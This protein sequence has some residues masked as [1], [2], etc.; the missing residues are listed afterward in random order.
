[1]VVF[2]ALMLLVAVGIRYTL[3]LIWPEK[4][5]ESL[6][7]HM[8]QVMAYVR[9]GVIPPLNTRQA[10][11]VA[12]TVLAVASAINRVDYYF[13][14]HI[15]LYN[16]QYR[17]R[18]GHRDAQDVVLRSLDFPPGTQIHIFTLTDPPDNNVTVGMLEF[19]V[20]DLDLHLIPTRTTEVADYIASLDHSVDQAFYVGPYNIRV[21]EVLRGEFDLLP[22]LLSPSNLPA[23]QQFVLY[24]APRRAE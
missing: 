16:Q 15:P 18:W 3:P 17:E 13:N 2:P 14:I 9:A 6:R 1:V 7:L 11:L 10:Q 8:E 21:I 5:G 23:D 12:M 4:A 22:P 19:M 24:Y 20:S